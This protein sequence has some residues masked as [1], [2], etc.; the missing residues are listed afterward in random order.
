MAFLNSRGLNMR[1]SSLS[2]FCSGKDL[3]VFIKL[4]ILESSWL[5]ASNVRITN[6]DLKQS[7]TAFIVQ[8]L[9]PRRPRKGIAAFAVFWPQ[10]V[11]PDLPFTENYSQ[12]FTEFF[13]NTEINEKREREVQLSLHLERFLLNSIHYFGSL[14][15]NFQTKSWK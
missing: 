7:K 10:F 14:V 11:V 2:R 6:L 3:N 13:T 15:E 8:N 1:R 9:W 4:D 5:W 12:F